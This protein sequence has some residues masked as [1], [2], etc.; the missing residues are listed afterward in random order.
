M[1]R[2]A[3]PAP[4]I[5]DGRERWA[6]TYWRPYPCRQEF[7]TLAEAAAFI[8]NRLDAEEVTS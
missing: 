8:A 1:F 2:F 7:E 4:F 5:E 3:P 6:V